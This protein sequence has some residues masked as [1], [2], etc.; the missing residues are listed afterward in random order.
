MYQ[1]VSS[2][3]NM[4]MRMNKREMLKG[5]LKETNTS[6]ISA[7]CENNDRRCALVIYFNY[8]CIAKGER[9][10]F[11]EAVGGEGVA[12]WFQW[13]CNFNR[14]YLFTYLTRYLTRLLFIRIVLTFC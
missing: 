4:K 12:L 13:A 5:T 9:F 6:N 8:R 3:Q 2:G 7:M 11:G 1:S 14:L 10:I